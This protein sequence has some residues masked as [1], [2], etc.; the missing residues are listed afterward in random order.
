VVS[1]E[2]LEVVGG[3]DE[4][5]GFSRYGVEDFARRVR[6]ANFLIACCEDATR[7]SSRFLKRVVRRQS[8]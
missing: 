8:R 3:F 5:F 2:A 4:M 7:I 6:A 1:R